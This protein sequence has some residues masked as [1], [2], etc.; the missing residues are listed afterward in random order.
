MKISFN[1]SILEE[2]YKTP[3]KYLGKQQYSR[4]VIERYRKG[5]DAL[6]LAND[7]G[8]IARFRG[9][10]LEKLKSSA[11]KGCYSIRANIQYRIIFKE[12]KNGQIE[13]LILELSKH[14]E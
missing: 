12:V 6:L 3:L 1:D 5:I 14:Y 13:I 9:F 2:L 10:N 11:F 8:E 7:L 4:E